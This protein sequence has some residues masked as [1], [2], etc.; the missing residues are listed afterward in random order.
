MAREGGYQW[1]ILRHKGAVLNL[2]DCRARGNGYDAS[3]R[4]RHSGDQIPCENES[5]YTS[6]NDGPERVS[7]ES[8]LQVLVHEILLVG[9]TLDTEILRKGFLL[10]T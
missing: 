9:D 10:N 2:R 8:L 6:E 5:K 7:S 1:G 4:S 3:G